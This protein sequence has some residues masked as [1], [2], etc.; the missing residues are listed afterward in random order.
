MQQLTGALGG[1]A[2]GF[3]PHDG[4]VGMGLMMLAFAAIGAWM[5]HLLRVRVA[6]P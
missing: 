4:P 6:R 3:V 5:H 2:V 1:Y